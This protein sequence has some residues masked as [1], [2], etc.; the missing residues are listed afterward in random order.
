MFDVQECDRE[1]CEGVRGAGVAE[2]GDF[3]E[4]Y[5]IEFGEVER[6]I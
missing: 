1:G 4:W 5:W 2:Y 3:A 6:E